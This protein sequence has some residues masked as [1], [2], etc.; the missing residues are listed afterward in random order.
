VAETSINEMIS[1]ALKG[2]AKAAVLD[3]LRELVGGDVFGALQVGYGAGDFEDA[4]LGVGEEL[5]FGDAPFH[6]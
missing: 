1:E 3:G 4:G 2:S 6:A 5:E